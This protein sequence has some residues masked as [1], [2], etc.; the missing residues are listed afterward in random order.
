MSPVCLLLYFL[1]LVF[2]CVYSFVRERVLGGYTKLFWV[3]YVL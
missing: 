2:L 3:F 1:W